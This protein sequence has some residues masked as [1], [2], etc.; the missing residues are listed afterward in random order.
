MGYV[1]VSSVPVTRTVTTTT[2]TTPQ[3]PVT[4]TT[5]ETPVASSGGNLPSWLLPLGV[6]VLVVIA[7]IALARGHSRG[8][9]RYRGGDL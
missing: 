1:T 6:V 3:E 7:I 2:V 5:T 8:G 9:G 4:T